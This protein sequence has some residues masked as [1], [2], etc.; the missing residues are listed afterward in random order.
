MFIILC[1]LFLF[2][3]GV[4]LEHTSDISIGFHTFVD[5]PVFLITFSSFLI[6]MLFAIPLALSFGKKRKKSAK[7]A[8][9]PSITDRE[10]NV[11]D[12]V[13]GKAA[14]DDAAIAAIYGE[15][16]KDGNKT[17]GGKKEKSPYGID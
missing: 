14:F 2:F 5:I 12:K 4:N 8:P 7:T 16:G 15:S 3:V 10:G 11:A 6:G 13:A 9:T 17:D 1:A